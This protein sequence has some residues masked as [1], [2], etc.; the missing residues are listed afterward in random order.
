MATTITAV[1]T[2]PCPSCG[3]AQDA[4]SELTDADPSV[5]ACHQCH[6]NLVFI[7]QPTDSVWPQSVSVSPKRAPPKPAPQSALVATGILCCLAYLA[8]GLALY[9]ASYGVKQLAP[10]KIAE[11]FVA[12]H[13]VVTAG[14]GEPVEFGWFP[15]VHVQS[16][17]RRGTAYVN[18]AVS[19]SRTSGRIAVFLDGDQSDW[20]VREAQYQFDEAEVTPLWVQFPGD[21]D[22]LVRL[23]AVMAELDEA[24]NAR[25][26]DAM[27]H[28][29]APN[30]RFRFIH[31]LTKGRDVRTY[32]N[33]EEYRRE[34]LAG[35][36]MVQDLT[37][38]RNHTEFELAPDG[39]TATG[40]VEATQ[41]V[42]AGGRT[43]T[44]HVQE[45]LTY[46]LHGETPVITSIDGVQQVKR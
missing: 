7:P 27:M 12:R 34:T 46:A 43:V 21:H 23:E 6:V 18:F 44:F 9:G 42:V 41:K 5:T 37:W 2:V 32:H 36:L 19:G 8:L 45:T 31:E 35:I 40:R 10:Y 39:R 20:R 26:V 33:R 1:S 4:P 17:G 29:V 30:A 13:P 3:V 11:S 28:H 38:V 15:T 24:T 22:L 14:V 25:D 16:R